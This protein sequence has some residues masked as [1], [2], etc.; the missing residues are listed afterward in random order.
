[1]VQPGPKDVLEIALTPA[2][3]LDAVRSLV[4]ERL[5]L[6]SLGDL[7]TRSVVWEC[8]VDGSVH[9]ST[10][11]KL[12]RQ[13]DALRI[14]GYSEVQIV[15]SFIMS[16]SLAALQLGL[17]AGRPSYGGSLGVG[18]DI[19]PLTRLFGCDLLVEF[20]GMVGYSRAVINSTNLR[21]AV[22]DDVDLY[23]PSDLYEHT[24]PSNTERM[25]QLLLGIHRPNLLFNFDRFADLYVRQVIPMSAIF[26]PN[27]PLYPVL[28]LETFGVP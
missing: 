28:H 16:V 26:R 4:T 13:W 22:R 3:E 24:G 7:R 15:E 23:L 17:L 2:M 12:R 9:S 1:M 5:P 11:D 8:V 18:E 19:E 14:D 25:H 27:L 6:A 10:S 20:T 21:S